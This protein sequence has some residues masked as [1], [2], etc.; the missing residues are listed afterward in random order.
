MVG[1]HF[2]FVH[3]SVSR[4]KFCVLLEP[5]KPAPCVLNKLDADDVNGNDVVDGAVLDDVLV[6]A[7]AAAALRL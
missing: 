2:V 1:G 6:A 3:G 5:Y 4:D 7:A